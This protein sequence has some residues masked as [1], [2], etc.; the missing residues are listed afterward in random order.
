[1][2]SILQYIVFSTFIKV[3]FVIKIFVLSIFEWPLKTG[4]TV[5]PNPLASNE[6]SWSG[7]TL[8]LSTQSIRI[9]PYKLSL[10]FVGHRQT[11]QTKISC[12]IKLRLIKVFTVCLKNILCTFELIRKITPST[13]KIWNR[14]DL[15][16]WMGKFIHLKWV[17]NLIAPLYF[18]QNVINVHL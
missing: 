1:M 11:V 4:F 14:L 17:N 16:I 8:F 18:T 5:D 15:S 7:S 12:R 6:A 3:P 2:G 13:P 9:N 10:L